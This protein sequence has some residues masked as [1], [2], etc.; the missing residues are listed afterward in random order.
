METFK[1]IL[2]SHFEDGVRAER[3][4]WEMERTINYVAPA[5]DSLRIEKN[6]GSVDA[7]MMRFLIYEFN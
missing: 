1:L 2:F 3:D 5:T 7:S 4:Y 6:R